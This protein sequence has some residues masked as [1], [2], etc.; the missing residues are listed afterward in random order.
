MLRRINKFRGSEREAGG[1]GSEAANA[2]VVVADRGRKIIL[3]R[4]GRRCYDFVHALVASDLL[5]D[6]RT[7]RIGRGCFW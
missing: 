3:D 7:K 4:F 6:A 5:E 1:G 2:A